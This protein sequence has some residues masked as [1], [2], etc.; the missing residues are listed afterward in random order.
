M[1]ETVHERL[2]PLVK[3]GKTVDEVLAN[4]PLKDLDG[5]WGQSFM[6]PDVF[7]RSAY[8]SLLRREKKA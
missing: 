3:S 1:L 5:K 6:K 4:S 8:M 2:I 7:L